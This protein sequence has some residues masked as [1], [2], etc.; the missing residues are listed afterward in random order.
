MRT[1]DQDRHNDGEGYEFSFR[2]GY[3]TR[4]F[5]HV[6]KASL[7]ILRRGCGPSDSPLS[8]IVKHNGAIC[9]LAMARSRLEETTR[10]V[11]TQADAESILA[12]ATSAGSS[13]G[14]QQPLH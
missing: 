2:P 11:M 1:F 6:P 5:V 4:V 8:L 14:V 12:H 3:G 7:A 9:A 13:L 10:V